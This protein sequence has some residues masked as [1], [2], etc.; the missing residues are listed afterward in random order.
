MVGIFLVFCLIYILAISGTINLII[1]I[2][3]I[4]LKRSFGKTLLIISLACLTPFTWL[5][6][7]ALLDKKHK[8][9]WF[10]PFIHVIEKQD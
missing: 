10:A 3:L 8:R 7:N 2:I 4:K 1:S 9:N 5:S 6:I